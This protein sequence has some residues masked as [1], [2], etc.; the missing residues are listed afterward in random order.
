M[1]L[2]YDDFMKQ[3]LLLKNEIGNTNF[4]GYRRVEDY[5]R[6]LGYREHFDDDP[7][8]AKAHA[9]AKLFACHEKF[10]YDNDLVAGSL[11]GC[12]SDVISDAELKRANS[13]VGSFG[14]NSFFT[15]FDHYAADFESALHF[16]VGGIFNKINVSLDKH[17]DENKRCFL[18]AAKITM[19]AFSEMIKGY[20]GAAEQKGL[21]EVSRI[22][23]K[24]AW[25]KPDSFHEALQLI[26]FIHTSFLYEGRFSMA[27]GRL[28]QYLY[29]FYIKDSI[30]GDRATELIACTLYKIYERNRFLEG[31]MNLGRDDVVNIAVGGVKRDGSDAVNELS[32]IIL[33][34]VKAC[35]IPGP[36]L[37]ARI[38]VKNPDRFVD[39]CLEVIGTGIG[40]PALMNDEV[41]VAALSRYG[42]D[43]EDC[44]DYAMVGCIENFIPGKQPPWSDGR[45]N[46]PKYI[47]LALN[48]GICKLTGMQIGPKTGEAADI[49]I[50][51]E[52]LDAVQKQMSHGAAEYVRMFN[53]EA[54]RYDRQLYSQPYLSCYHNDCIDR[55]LDIRDGG[56]VYPSIHGAACMG[57][58]TVTDSLAA[59]EKVVFEDKVLSLAQLNEALNSDF[60][61]F[62]DVRRI[63]LKAPKYGNN[64]DFADKYA[65]WFVDTHYEL[66][67]KYR[68]F[69]DGGFYIAIASNIDNIPA[70]YEV[71]ATPDGRKSKEPLSDAASPGHG[72]DVNG[73]TASL[74][75]CSK[76]DF[77]KVACGTVLNV[78]FSG[79]TFKSKNIEKLR[80]LVRVYFER[81]GQEMQ[82][83]CVSKS[84]LEDASTNPQK[85]KDLVVRVSGFSAFY[86]YLDESVQN[87]ILERTEHG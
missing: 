74:L 78:K 16:G 43:I 40:Y 48:N 49:K 7:L 45:F 63:L 21:L 3:L 64:D 46:S 5:Y 34:A 37:S 56:S 18:N 47:E 55:G 61:G 28:D 9:V 73:I 22:C 15:N 23:N 25:E 38:S 10:V 69:D 68:T 4:S 57:I 58:A 35:H 30:S 72:F 85:Y 80:G 44:R 66:F 71:A 29:P 24:V 87:D 6:Y 14:R 52:F 27:L 2:C 81:G 53:N 70:G 19:N 82:I 41:N 75:S 83:N 60:E 17:R 54:M 13:V 59:I 39:K 62:E 86:V 12:Y 26:W 8:I 84:M 42:Y 67:S 33:D 50:M 51:P 65:C 20:A 11:R 77:T 76:P 79:S 36:N 32:Y 31:F 1:F